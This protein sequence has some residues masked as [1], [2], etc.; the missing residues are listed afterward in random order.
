MTVPVPANDKR[1]FRDL[2]RDELATP[3]VEKQYDEKYEEVLTDFRSQGDQL[4]QEPA[5]E[6]NL[7]GAQTGAAGVTAVCATQPG[8]C[9]SDLH[10][11]NDGPDFL[12][13]NMAAMKQQGIETLFIEHFW[14]EQQ[15]LI[16][17][18]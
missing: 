17:E 10:G 6:P 4:Y 18:F 14:Q 13:N 15:D 5:N 16:D 3:A 8:M 7:A 9:L 1:P 2:F 12:I 11:S